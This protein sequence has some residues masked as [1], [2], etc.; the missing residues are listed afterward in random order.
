MAICCPASPEEPKNWGSWR[1]DWNH[2]IEY[3]LPLGIGWVKGGNHSITSGIIQGEGT[4]IIEEVY[5]ISAVY[6]HVICDGDTF[7]RQH[8]GSKIA[9]VKNVEFAGIFEIGRL[10]LQNGVSA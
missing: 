8:D 3:W 10:M 6:Q 4:I 5:D 1:Q 9:S 7:R 2:D